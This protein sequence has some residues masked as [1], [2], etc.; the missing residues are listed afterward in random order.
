[1]TGSSDPFDL[2]HIA[3]VEE[4]DGMNVTVAG[5]KDVGDAELIVGADALDFAEDVRQLGARNHAVLCAVTRRQ[6]P[7]GSEGL[8]AAL[9]HQKPFRV[10]HRPAHVAG[11]ISARDGYD[12]LRIGIE[13]GL[14]A[15]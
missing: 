4:D 8:L 13:T 15:V 1:M 9:P 11:L 10:A 7:D 14:Q 3:L 2:F 6:P 5:V 12:A